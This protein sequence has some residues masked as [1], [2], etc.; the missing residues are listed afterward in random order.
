MAIIGTYAHRGGLD[1]TL[2]ALFIALGLSLRGRDVEFMQISTHPL[3]FTFDPDVELPFGCRAIEWEGVETYRDVL[4]MIDRAAAEGRDLVIDFPAVPLVGWGGLY[5]RV[6]AVLVPLRPGSAYF[7]VAYKT[8]R[9]VRLSLEHSETP[10]AMPWLLPFGWSSTARARWQIR[11]NLEAIAARGDDSLPPRQLI[12]WNVP[13]LMPDIMGALCDP[14]TIGHTSAL[15]PVADALAGIALR[16]AEDPGGA[17]EGA[18]DLFDDP[19]GGAPGRQG[20]PRDTP[21]RISE[22]AEDLAAIKAGQGPSQAELDA[23]PVLQDWYLEPEVGWALVGRVEGHPDLDARWIRT[24]PLYHL[25][26][27]RSFA[28]TLSRYYRLGRRRDE[29]AQ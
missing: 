12:P 28:R 26:A 2:T 5:Q 27:L 8:W 13:R 16:L 6:G 11:G 4:E 18:S 22:L 21:Q 1:A 19:E 15:R 7:D 10:D 20:D 3:N 24:S 14:D 9:I 17:F 23:A 29:D 25:D